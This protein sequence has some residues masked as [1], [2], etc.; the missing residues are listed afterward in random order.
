[1]VQHISE[2][3]RLHTI[4]INQSRWVNTYP[5]EL[6]GRPDQIATLDNLQQLQP[7]LPRIT[8]HQWIL[9]QRIPLDSTGYPP[10]KYR[11]DELSQ[12]SSAEIYVL[13]IAVQVLYK[14][15]RYADLIPLELVVNGYVVDFIPP[16]NIEG[17]DTVRIRLPRLE[18][19]FYRFYRQWP[20]SMF[21]GYQLVLLQS[22]A[23]RRSDRMVD[24]RDS[25]SP[26]G[27]FS[28]T[29]DSGKAT[30]GDSE[31]DQPTTVL[32]TES[33]QP[34]TPSPIETEKLSIPRHIESENSIE[35]LQYP[36]P[37]NNVRTWK[38][39]RTNIGSAQD[40]NERDNLVAVHSTTQPLNDSASVSS[41]CNSPVSP[42]WEIMQIDNDISSSEDSEPDTPPTSEDL[43]IRPL[44]PLNLELK[45][46]QI[47][48]TDNEATSTTDDNDMRTPS[49]VLTT[50][51]APTIPVA[52]QRRPRSDSAVTAD[53][54]RLLRLK[55]GMKQSETIPET[56]E[57]ME[58]GEVKEVLR[59]QSDMRDEDT[60][61]AEKSNTLSDSMPSLESVNRTEDEEPRTDRRRKRYTPQRAFRH[62]TLPQPILQ[63]HTPF[64]PTAIDSGTPQRTERHIY[65]G[66]ALHS[67]LAQ[68]KLWK[69]FFRLLTNANRQLTTLSRI[70]FG[71]RRSQ[72]R[73][74]HLYDIISH[75]DFDELFQEHH[76][77]DELERSI[78]QSGDIDDFNVWQ[79]HLTRLVEA[80]QI[81]AHMLHAAEVFVRSHGY[82]NGISTYMRIQQRRRPIQQPQGHI[83][84]LFFPSEALYLKYLHHFLFK[85]NQK[86][87]CSR[88]MHISELRFQAEDDLRRL[89]DA[90]LSRITPTDAALLADEVTQG[91]R[92]ASV[93]L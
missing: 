27:E 13:V 81:T 9:G 79:A 35:E 37:G 51:A 8:L 36:S 63:Q 22:Q 48:E 56:D 86:A 45:N 28:E 65:Q 92:H 52:F 90:I 59:M 7:V 75:E 91:D 15:R 71:S 41:T 33:E 68:E 26:S 88:L 12:F 44:S 55:H 77:Y 60:A 18:V 14:Q 4:L 6:I 67:N 11:D 78:T 66:P 50:T 64:S 31:A 84:P 83:L 24:C 1:M 25:P 34:S 53:V 82:V 87:A 23:Q 54:I 73:L 16:P 30:Y 19:L 42:S 40:N 70:T 32:G 72:R 10:F 62:R 20:T 57:E 39:W 3:D 46:L 74:V 49:T 69:R 5:R 85:L 43:P 89:S 58:E 80:R 61:T 93:S 2:S 38:Q 47:Q 29:A 17:P 21:K 76:T